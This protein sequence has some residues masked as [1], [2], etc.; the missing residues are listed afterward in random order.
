LLFGTILWLYCCH[1]IQA[2]PTGFVDE[3][4]TITKTGFTTTGVF[5]R[6]M[7]G[8]N[9]LFLGAKR[10]KIFVMINPDT[11]DT[12]NQV[13]LMQLPVCDNGERGVQT[14]VA[15]PDFETNGYLY[16][17]R[18][19]YKEGCYLDS[20]TGPQNRLSRFTVSTSNDN[21]GP[22]IDPSTELSLFRGPIQNAYNHNGG[23]MA[24]GNDGYLYI[25]I[26]D[27]GRIGDYHS[28]NR[29]T[30]NGSILR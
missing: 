3:L 2:V 12:S 18:T 5:A 29:Q 8:D 11:G 26:G 6:T 16:I 22:T 30:L 1:C 24:F 14:I 13:I 25:A 7:E 4:V 17:Y 20:T 23:G 21:G 15:H 10:G 19:E 9:L 27:G 28:Q